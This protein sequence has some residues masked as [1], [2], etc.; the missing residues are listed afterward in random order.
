MDAEDRQLLIGGLAALA[1][2]GLGL[3]AYLG[4]SSPPPAQAPVDADRRIPLQAH[5]APRGPAAAG[6]STTRRAQKPLLTS[7]IREPRVRPEHLSLR[8]G[9]A[10][11]T[12][13]AAFAACYATELETSPKA[14]GRAL[15]QLS[16]DESSEVTSANVELRGIPS[17]ALKGC[18]MAAAQE[19][20]FGEIDEPAIVW[21]PL[22]MWPDRGLII[23]TAA[24]E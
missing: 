13:E 3:A 18:L 21:W 15:L 5:E 22:D 14:K 1:V 6:S 23:Q 10:L 12:N 11:R 7:S 16:I 19:I 2:L 24:G 9:R 20:V 8:V 4:A 17:L